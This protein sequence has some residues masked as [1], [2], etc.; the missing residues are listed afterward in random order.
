M[1]MDTTNKWKP[2]SP[3]SDEELAA[4]LSKIVG[5]EEGLP[6]VVRD[7]SDLRFKERIERLGFKIVDGDDH[8][9]WSLKSQGGRNPRPC[10]ARKSGQKPTVTRLLLAS[11]VEEE[12][13]AGNRMDGAHLCDNDQCVRP[14]GRHS[15]PLEKAFHREFDHQRKEATEGLSLRDSLS[16][17]IDDKTT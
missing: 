17:S 6:W 13:L 4:V 16:F 11:Y 5:V 9:F 10:Y 1:I 2:T 15:A 8:W 3:A 12:L 7:S 14:G